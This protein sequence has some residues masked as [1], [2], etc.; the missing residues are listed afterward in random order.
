MQKNLYLAI[1][2]TDEGIIK[3]LYTS[4]EKL[5]VEKIKHISLTYGQNEELCQKKFEEIEISLEEKFGMNDEEWTDKEWYVLW[6]TFIE[7]ATGGE[8]NDEDGFYGIIDPM[9]TYSIEKFT[10]DINE[11]DFSITVLN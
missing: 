4:L 1:A 10:I 2:D 7:W 3:D 5:I 9:D 11:T 6:E 8:G